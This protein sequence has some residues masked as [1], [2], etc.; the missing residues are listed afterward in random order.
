MTIES[1]HLELIM[2]NGIQFDGC[3]GIEIINNDVNESVTYY[4]D[5]NEMVI[6]R[7]HL[8]K[9]IKQIK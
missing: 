6:I 5:V 1:G 2:D 7:D 8:N 9:L 3:V 4:L